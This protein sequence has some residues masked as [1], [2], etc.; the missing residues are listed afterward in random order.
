MLA[1]SVL[2]GELRVG[3]LHLA[4]RYLLELSRRMNEVGKNTGPCPLEQERD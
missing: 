4:V 2:L 1:S 3:R